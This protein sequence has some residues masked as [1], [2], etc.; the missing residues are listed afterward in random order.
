MA[1][2]TKTKLAKTKLAKTKATSAKTPLPVAQWPDV[3]R[4]AWL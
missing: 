2:A 3:D 4:T 1:K